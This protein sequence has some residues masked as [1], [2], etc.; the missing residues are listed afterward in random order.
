MAETD[1]L[2]RVRPD[3]S[4]SAR[5]RL[6]AESRRWVMRDLRG[7]LGHEVPVWASGLFARFGVERIETWS[8]STWEAVALEILWRVCLDGIAGVPAIEPSNETPSRH[9]DLIAR[10]TGHDPDVWVHDLLVRFCSAFLDQGISQWPL[11]NRSD[12]FFKS[13]LL[14]YSRPGG[15]P[16]SWLKELRPECDRLLKGNVSP[17]ESIQESLDLLGVNEGEWEDYLS[18][19]LLAL[20]GWAGMLRQVELRGDRVA[21]PVPAGTLVEFVAVRLLLDRLA[22]ADA[23]EDAGSLAG[24]RRRLSE[25]FHYSNSHNSSAGRRTNCADSRPESGRCW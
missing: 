2:R 23:V 18:A 21:Q 4:A 20:R 22:A 24:L 14:L 12:G 1:A 13:F 25:R 9:R 6:V 15:P 19:T 10:V 11:P 5:G 3:V 8:E 7:R 17:L 16:H